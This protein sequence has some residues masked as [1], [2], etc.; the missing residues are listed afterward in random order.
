MATLRNSARQAKRMIDPMPQNAATGDELL[1]TFFN[2]LARMYYS[3]CDDQP[4]EV[5][6]YIFKQLERV[7]TLDKETKK[8]ASD[9]EQAKWR[10]VAFEGIKR[11]ANEMTGSRDRVVLERWKGQR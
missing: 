2:N 7:I 11:R 8:P 1:E 9:E 10:A 5:R 4:E 3:L 6:E